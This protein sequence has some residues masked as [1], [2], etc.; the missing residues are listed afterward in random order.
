M[1]RNKKGNSEIDIMLRSANSIRKPFE[2]ED[3]QFDELSRLVNEL[4]IDKE[5]EKNY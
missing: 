1:L 3:K 2:K 4:N 5:N